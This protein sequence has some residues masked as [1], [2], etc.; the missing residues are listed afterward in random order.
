LFRKDGEGLR[1]DQPDEPKAATSAYYDT[2]NFAKRLRTPVLYYAGYNDTVTPPTST[3]A[4]YNVIPTARTL[5]VEP[6]QVHLTSQAHRE[7]IERWLLEH[8]AGKR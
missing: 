5:V 6:D 4:V 7:T 8:A 1:R 2:V 3:F